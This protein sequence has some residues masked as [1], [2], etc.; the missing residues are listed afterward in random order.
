MIKTFLILL[1]FEI[2][3]FA[4]QQIILVVADDFQTPKAKLICYEDANQVFEKVEINLGTNGLA[5]GLGEVPLTQKVDEPLKYEGDKKSP[6]G[7]FKLT[8]I[9]GYA[10]DTNFSMP[11]LYA[12]KELICVDESDS[13][14]YNQIIQ[15]RGDEKSFEYMKRKDNQYELGIVVAH[16]KNASAGRGSCIFVHI[17]KSQEASTA[18]CSAMRLDE[19]QKISAWLDKK[20]NPILIQIPKSS[21]REIINLYPQLKES[22]LLQEED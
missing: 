3:L 10:K 13:P 2:F 14:F 18:G 20:K 7:V 9:Y 21:S 1:S 17:K 22:E 4:S 11:Y 12:S 19:I 5:W 8:D 16:N 6:S 15:K